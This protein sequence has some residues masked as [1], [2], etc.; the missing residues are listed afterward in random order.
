M[1]DQPNAPAAAEEDSIARRVRDRM[2]KLNIS[3]AQVAGEAGVTEQTVRHWCRDADR[4]YAIH[5]P[6]LARALRCSVM[7]LLGLARH[8]GR[9]PE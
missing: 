9:P 3:Y 8:V 6:R 7:W 5:V 1:T 2:F 4:M